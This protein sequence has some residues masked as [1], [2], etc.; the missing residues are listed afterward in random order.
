MVAWPAHVMVEIGV[1]GVIVEGA[2]LHQASQA[3]RPV[4]AV[5]LDVVT[6]ELIDADEDDQPRSVG[7]D[8][9]GRRR[10]GC[11]GGAGAGERSAGGDDQENG[12]DGACG[13]S[14]R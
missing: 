13:S 8:G 2:V 14:H 6:T 5:A 11:L 4:P 3:R 10:G 9:R 12:A 7:L 1:G